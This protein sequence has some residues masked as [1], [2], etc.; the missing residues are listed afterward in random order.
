MGLTLKPRTSGCVQKFNPFG[1]FLDMDPTH[2]SPS[3]PYA[4][5]LLRFDISLPSLKIY[6]R[7]SLDTLKA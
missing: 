5:R 3:L 7:N 6:I 2:L 4:L 1:V